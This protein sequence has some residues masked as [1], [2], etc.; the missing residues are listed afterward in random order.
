MLYTL[1]RTDWQK[2]KYID[3]AKQKMTLSKKEKIEEPKSFWGLTKIIFKKLPEITTKA[4][5]DTI[6]RVQNKAEEVVERH[7][8]K[9]YG[10][11]KKQIDRAMKEKMINFNRQDVKANN[12]VRLT[13]KSTASSRISKI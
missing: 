2:Q 8:M 13:R 1:I 10:A 12:M 7:Y 5:G 3:N 4:I 9:E 6:A 11:N